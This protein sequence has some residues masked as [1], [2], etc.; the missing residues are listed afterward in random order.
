MFPLTPVPLPSHPLPLISP[1]PPHDSRPAQAVRQ[2]LDPKELE[3]VLFGAKDSFR[4]LGV[5]LE[6]ARVQVIH[7]LLRQ[8]QPAGVG[9]VT[10][11]LLQLL[12]AW[13]DTTGVRGGLRKGT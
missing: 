1:H 5:G 13:I 9:V 6:H 3:D 10:E 8:V 2:V 4:V 12:V 7:G 11:V